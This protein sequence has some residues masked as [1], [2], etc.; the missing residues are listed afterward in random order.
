MAL[1]LARIMTRGRRFIAEVDGLRFIA[2]TAVVLYHL[3]G[4]TLVKHM[5][6]A[7]LRPGEAWLPR[8]FGIGHYGVQLF[9]VLSGFLLVMPFAKWKLGLSPK[10]SL[11]TY[12]L[13]RLTRLEPP[14]IIAMLLLFVGGM[15]AFG[16]RAGLTYWPNLLASLIYQHTAILGE[17]NRIAIIAWSLE[18]KVQFYVF[19]PLLAAAAFSIRNA[20]TRRTTFLAVMILLPVLRDLLPFNPGERLL[21]SLPWHLEFFVAGFFLADLFLVQ[22]KEDPRHSLRWDIVSLVGWPALATLMMWQKFPV[23]LAPAILVI[24]V[25]SFRGWL[26]SRLFSQRIIT[27]LGGMCY[28]MYLLHYSIISIGGRI[29][30]RI[31]FGN[32]FTSRFAIDAIVLLPAV[33]ILSTVFFLLLERPCM[34]SRWPSK[35]LASIREMRAASAPIRWP[36]LSI[37]PTKGY[38]P[39]PARKIRPLL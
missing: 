34:D 19:A 35:L 11:R 26:S 25:A 37:S 23:L 24:Y 6:G 38:I 29:S 4:Y 7:E 32:T 10:P 30:Q 9:F 1:E 13:R 31:A 16:T 17:R 39:T 28:S 21:D 20:L 18:I 14:Y 15:V 33:L 3:S 27:V 12:Y 8:V 5:A 2:I 22:W 36:I